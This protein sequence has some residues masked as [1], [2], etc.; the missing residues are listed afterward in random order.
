M[1]EYKPLTKTIWHDLEDLFGE[2]GACGGCWCMYWRLKN[3]EYEQSKGEKNKLL[4]KAFADNH[5][6]LGIL[7]YDKNKAVGWCSVSPRE[8]LKRLETSRLFK[9]MDETSVWSITCLYVN[10]AYRNKGLSADLMAKSTEYAFKNGAK[11]VEAYP[12][13]PLKG[14]IPDVFAWVGLKGAFEKAGFK[15]VKRV[16]ENR[17]IVRKFNKPG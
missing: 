9:P 2:K 11:C 14:K 6:H 12:I 13:D 15:E 3:K 16:S 8:T 7:A 4:L 10:K 1:I 5:E 17:S